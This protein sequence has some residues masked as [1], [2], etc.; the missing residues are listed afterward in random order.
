[1]LDL[2]PHTMFVNL[3]S[4]EF[5]T[6]TRAASILVSE[7]NTLRGIIFGDNNSPSKCVSEP[8]ISEMADYLLR[9]FNGVIPKGPTPLLG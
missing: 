4:I 1:M 8:R 2:V 3:N 7:T 5:E 6:Y 9:T